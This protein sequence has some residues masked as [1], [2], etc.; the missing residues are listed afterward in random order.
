MASACLQF[1]A[2]Q[3]IYIYIYTCLCVCDMVCIYACINLNSVCVCVYVCVRAD[4]YLVVRCEI[5]AAL[6]TKDGGKVCKQNA[7]ATDARART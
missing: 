7:H 3:R 6:E 2:H 5:D 4:L 1:S